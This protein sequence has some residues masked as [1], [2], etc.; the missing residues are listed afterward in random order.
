M[1]I[2][3]QTYPFS[4]NIRYALWRT[5]LLLSTILLSTGIAYSQTEKKSKKSKASTSKTSTSKKKN[6]KKAEPKSVFDFDLK[7]GVRTTYDDNILK[8]SDKY[9]QRFINNEDEGRFHINSHDDIVLRPSLSTSIAKDF[10]GKLSTEFDFNVNRSLY[11]NN[12]IKSWTY[13]SVG[14]RQY[15]SKKGSVKF[16]YSYIPD[17]YIRHYRDD[18]YTSV[19]GYVPQA[20]KTMAFSKESFEFWTHYNLLKKTGIRATVDYKRYFY[21]SFYT[22]YDSKDLTGE[23]KI[24]QTLTDN[25]RIQLAYSFT[26]SNAKGYD[27]PGETTENSN[28]ADAT[29]IDNSFE[30][31]INYRLPR[32]FGLKH[33]ITLDG[34]FGERHFTTKNFLEEDPLHAGRV[35]KNYGLSLSYDVRV[36]KSIDATLFYNFLKRSTISKADINHDMVSEEKDYEQNQIGFSLVYRFKL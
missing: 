1:Q 17:F 31:S 14:L 27:E 11:L 20:F 34:S 3:K 21:N 23:I 4:K 24:Y 15:F 16:S 13:L 9:L 33:D 6:K 22:E 32:I 25:I 29:F 19:L 36:S 7:V 30:A 35:D 8:Y 12:D 2:K 26:K 28:D 18:D 5:F 10:V